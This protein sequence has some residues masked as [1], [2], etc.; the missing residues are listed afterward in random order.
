LAAA[1][2]AGQS[3][4]CAALEEAV[5]HNGILNWT[6]WQTKRGGVQ[7]LRQ[8]LRDWQVWLG[9][10]GP[11]GGLRRLV[12]ALNPLLPCASP[13]LGGRIVARLAE[14]VPALDAAAASA[15]RGKP[16]VDAHIAAFFAARADQSVINEVGQFEGFST[17]AERLRVLELFARVQARVSPAPAPGLAGWLL[18]CG[19]IEVEGWRNLDTRRAMSADLARLAAAGHILPMLLLAKDDGARDA[20]ETGAAQAAARLTEIAAELARLEQ[21]GPR[22]LAQAQR[23]GQ[24]IAAALALVAALAGA[25]ALAVLG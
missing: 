12:Y 22:R 1:Q 3:A 21:G 16:P 17:Q 15:D 13:L 25:S 23:S 2:A 19:L 9:Q 10:R 8:E 24:D 11:M 20:D 6:V 14:L 5:V 4:V 7:E 18:S